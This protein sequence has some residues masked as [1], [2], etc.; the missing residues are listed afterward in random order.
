MT[1][2]STPSAAPLPQRLK[3]AGQALG[4]RPAEALSQVE[5]ILAEDP[6]Q[7]AAA[8]IKGSA[9]R[10]LGQT[11]QALALLTSLESALTG[12]AA[13]QHD[14]GLCHAALGDHA[15]AERYLRRAVDLEPRYSAAWLSL[16]NLLDSTGDTGGSEAA[17]QRHLACSTRHPELITAAQHLQAGRL[18]QAEPLIKGVLK[19]D[20]TDVSAI[21]MLAD[22][23]FRLGRLQDARNLL[24]RCLE[25]AP[26]F[27]L[28]RQDYAACLRRLQHYPEALA[29]IESLLRDDPDNP[30]YL[31]LKGSVLTQLGEHGSA[32][33]IFER[34]IKDYPNQSSAQLSYGHN[35]KTLGRVDEAIAAYRRAV[36]ITPTAGEAYWSLANLKTF[37]F[38]D[39]D[40]AA[41]RAAIEAGGG[42]SDD[43]NHL[44]FALGKALE[45]RKEFEESF[46][47]YQLGN[48]MRGR[49]HP[50]HP[51]RAM[52]NAVRQTKTCTTE[53]FAARRGGGC[54]ARD[55]IFIVGLPRAGSTLLEQILASHSQVE[56]TTELPDIIA[57]SRELGGSRRDNP[58]TRYPEILKELTSEQRETLG[59]RYLD[60]TRIHRS[61]LPHFIDKMPNNWLHIG[62]IHL[63]L[64][65][66]KI[67][68]ARRHPMAG[69]FACYK[70][71][72]ARGQTFTY[73]LT[74]LGYYYRNYINVMDHW[75]RVLPGRVLRVQY[76]DMV[77]NPERQIR[78]VLDYCDL[79]FEEQCLRFYE[80]DRAVRTPSSEQVRQPIFREG[81]E[82][83]RNY[84][85]HLDPLRKALGP[86][87]ERYPI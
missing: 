2:L 28:A 45:D 6:G 3:Q 1:T 64:P 67:I 53:F 78:R 47:F 25:L 36:E 57:L 16:S 54:Q 9:L 82:Q 33:A 44:A 17:L 86:L 11:E 7:S 83:W 32:L 51:K 18:A 26:D 24:E 55:P 63:I 74:H 19:R 49:D 81:L 76:E 41:M 66:A 65:G 34:V 38:S 46:H 68:D 40:L 37:R 13:L 14:I 87:L 15:S 27:T 21:R 72:F 56:G 71:L 35:L 23:G 75:D 52:Y 73:D 43:Q 29:E 12:N 22:L 8:F 69:C 31:I 10:R 30:R 5:S 61:G 77:A 59:R 70:Q 4:P 39:E 84:E 48:R 85:A 80:T 42:D 60:S 62:L 79:P 50:Y 58:A 20:P